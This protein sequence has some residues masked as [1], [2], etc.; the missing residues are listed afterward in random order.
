MRRARARLSRVRELSY[1]LQDSGVEVLLALESLYDEVGRQ[2]VPETDVELVLTT[3]EHA[4]GTLLK[5]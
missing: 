2:V 1:L 5:H 3:S 4:N